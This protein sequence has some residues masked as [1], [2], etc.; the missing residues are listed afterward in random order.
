MGLRNQNNIMQENE[1]TNARA[2]AQNINGKPVLPS[3]SRILNR[4]AAELDAQ[5]KVQS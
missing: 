4:T 3:N 1:K 5:L 2:A